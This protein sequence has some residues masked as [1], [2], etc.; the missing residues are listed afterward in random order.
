MTTNQK[1]DTKQKNMLLEHTADK[2]SAGKTVKQIIYEHFSLSSRLVTKLKNCGGIKV[3]GK[4]V[5]VR[6]IL[7]ENDVLTL[8][9]DESESSDIEPCDIPIDVIYEDEYILAVNKPKAMPTH[10]SR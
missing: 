1:K 3:C 10:P 6:Y 9:V 8:S 5:T 4:V 2:E 7:K